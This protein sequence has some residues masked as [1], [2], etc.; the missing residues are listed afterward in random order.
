MLTLISF[1]L[2]WVSLAILTVM[3]LLARLAYTRSV[4][5]QISV[6]RLELVTSLANPHN[7]PYGDALEFLSSLGLAR[8][9]QSMTDLQLFF[10]AGSDIAAE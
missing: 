4:W 3:S 2:L 8:L 5:A 7:P 9:A 1:E 10:L 6:F